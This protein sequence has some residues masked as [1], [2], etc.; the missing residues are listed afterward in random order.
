MEK[1]K[2][3]IYSR[4]LVYGAIF[5]FLYVL[6]CTP[7]FLEIMEVKPILLIPAAITLAMFEGEFIGGLYGAFAGLLCGLSSTMIY[8]FDAILLL[9][10]TVAGG[11]LVI[12]LMRRTL[13]TAYLLV[14]VAMLMRC[15]LAYF[16]G[17]GIW[18]FENGLSIF[19]RSTVWVI[20]Y[21]TL[22]TPLFF[23]MWRRV[24]GFF[25]GDRE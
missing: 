4:F 14:F 11:L 22:L 8:G 18:G 16:F 3:F 10:M 7:G 12:Y 1:R 5:V 17:Y 13:I 23:W 9:A 20:L 15:S 25:G 21:S 6:Q 24:C 19:W 2:L